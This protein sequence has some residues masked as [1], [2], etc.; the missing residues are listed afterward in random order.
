MKVTFA[1]ERKRVRSNH[2]TT[3]WKNT[4]FKG[5]GG[6]QEVLEE[7]GEGFQ[8][9]YILRIYGGYMKERPIVSNKYYWFYFLT[10]TVIVVINVAGM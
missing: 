10:R 3:A 5:P 2:Q 4:N 8:V 6:R 9:K 7:L 1:F